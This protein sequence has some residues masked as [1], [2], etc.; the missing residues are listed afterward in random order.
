MSGP[1]VLA[2]C[3]AFPQGDTDDENLV[4]ACAAAGVQAEWGVWDDPSFDWSAASLVVVRSTWDYTGRLGEFLAW[5]NQVSE[6]TTIANSPVQLAWSADKSYLSI[7]AGAGVPA[8][9]TRVAWEDADIDPFPEG[10]FVVKPSVGAG[11]VGAGRFAADNPHSVDLA[12]SHAS[13]LRAAGRTPIVQPYLEWVDTRGETAMLYFGG[14]FSHAIRKVPM[15]PRP[16]VHGVGEGTSR[17]HLPSESATLRTPSVDE[18]RVAE[19]AL[20]AVPGGTTL[21]ARVD[22]LPS[23]N[24]PMASEV[25][26]IEPSLFLASSPGA[27]QRFVT[28]VATWLRITG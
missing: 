4:E 11:S 18:F 5:V 15:L 12:R 1:V 10:D 13:E 19:Q 3:A 17:A 22:L 26:L 23:P 6:V 21:Y 2:T 8:V 28:A 24:G 7:L 16:M 25:E 9:P 20:A 14:T 27:D